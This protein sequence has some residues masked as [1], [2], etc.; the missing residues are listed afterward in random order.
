MNLLP[1]KAFEQSG[2][3]S[4]GARV[5]RVQYLA[6]SARLRAPGPVAQLD[7]YV[8]DWP[9]I[10]KPLILI[11]SALS[12]GV[13]GCVGNAPRLTAEQ[14]S[15]VAKMGVY[16]PDEQHPGEYRVLQSISAADCS[17]APAG[18][19]VWGNAE[20]AIDTLKRKAAALEADAVINVRCGAVPLLNNC[21]AAQKCSGD[22][23][24]LR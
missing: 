8:P 11:L 15:R 16:K 23:V 3:A 2:S 22:A 20:R 12:L 24:A 18:G 17:G 6:P 21:W 7:R 13:A 1:N 4:S 9:R 10:M 5:R 19:R 14:Q